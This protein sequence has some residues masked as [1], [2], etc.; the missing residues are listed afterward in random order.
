MKK[1]NPVH[2]KLFINIDIE[3]SLIFFMQNKFNN[4]GVRLTECQSLKNP[5]QLNEIDLLLMNKN[6][7]QFFILEKYIKTQKKVLDKHEKSRNYDACR[8][9]KYSILQMEKFKQDFE[10]WFKNNTL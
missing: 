3:K 6:K 4:N 5:I 7:E 1:T 9:V 10:S 2:P 8:I